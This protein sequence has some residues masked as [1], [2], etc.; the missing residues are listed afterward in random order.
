MYIYDFQVYISLF[1]CLSLLITKYYRVFLISETGLLSFLLF[2]IEFFLS[3][4][5]SVDSTQPL[6]PDIIIYCL[7]YT[8]SVFLCFSLY[9]LMNVWSQMIEIYC[10]GIVHFYSKIKQYMLK[11]RL[12]STKANKPNYFGLV[13]FGL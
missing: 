12:I 3:K 6:M 10:S 13:R 11:F 7:Y 4:C 5:V 2:F 1:Y 8:P 9:K